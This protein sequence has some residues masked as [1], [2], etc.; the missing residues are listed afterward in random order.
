MRC[1][2]VCRRGQATIEFA[3]VLPVIVVI[4]LA[5]QWVGMGIT[6]DVNVTNA[7]HA[8][9]QAAAGTLDEIDA[10]LSCT[11]PT[12]KACVQSAVDRI[13]NIVD[14]AL[15]CFPPNHSNTD[16]DCLDAVHFLGGSAPSGGG[17]P[18]TWGAAFC[19][20]VGGCSVS[21]PHAVFTY[22]GDAA[23]CGPTTVACDTAA[24]TM[25]Q[26]IMEAALGCDGKNADCPGPLAPT[27]PTTP[28]TNPNCLVSG[29]DKQDMLEIVGGF[30]QLGLSCAAVRRSLGLDQSTATCE[31]GHNDAITGKP[32]NPWILTKPVAGGM[33]FLPAVSPCVGSLP[34]AGDQ[35]LKT[36]CGG[37]G[38]LIEEIEVHYNPPNNSSPI[39]ATAY[40]VPATQFTT[41]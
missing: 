30:A 15:P 13:T 25:V 6:T 2:S 22:M 18:P 26:S 19:G 5:M 38:A 34:A 40:A 3:I 10:A 29:C 14:A 31:Q 20:A 27:A 9:A 35:L 23:N 12:T 37:G 24:N 11:P 16:P 1:R 36:F 17:S 39:V 33:P 8:G 7:A 32:D 28:P 41:G 4:I 21:I